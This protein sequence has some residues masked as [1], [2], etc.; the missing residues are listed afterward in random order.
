[1]RA[2]VEFVRRVARKY[3]RKHRV[4][5]PPVPVEL[6]LFVEGF[7]VEVLDYPDETVGESWWEDAV[8]HIAVSRSLADG[9]RRFTLAHEFGHLA[10]GHHR[11]PLRDLSFLNARFR[12]LQAL[13]LETRDPMETEANQF[14]AE[15]LMPLALFRRDWQRN[16][17]PFLLAARYE[18]SVEAARWRVASL[19]ST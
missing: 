19:S 18:V 13:A 1:M 17:N 12:D 6:I 2:R 3:L 15:L 11:H 9:R 8:P 7:Q 14:A 10:L 16:P 5:A 4:A